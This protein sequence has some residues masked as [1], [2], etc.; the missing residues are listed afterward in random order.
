MRYAFECTSNLNLGNF[1]I[2]VQFRKWCL[3]H[4]NQYKTLKFVRRK[5]ILIKSEHKITLFKNFK[6][7]IHN[8]F[9]FANVL[10]LKSNNNIFIFIQNVF[11]L[12]YFTEIR[13]GEKIN[14]F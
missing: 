3:S 8:K 5:I 1:S 11:M 12:R 7:K 2:S 4:L 9:I 14:Q 13:K 6:K 10:V